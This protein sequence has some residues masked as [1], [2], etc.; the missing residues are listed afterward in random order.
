MSP[1]AS[2]AGTPAPT[3]Q[4]RGGARPAP[5]RTTSRAE[6]ARHP[7]FAELSPEVG[8]LDEDALESAVQ[9]DPDAVLALLADLGRAT[10]VGLRAAAHRLAGRLVLDRASTGAVRSAGS[11]RLRALPADRGGDLDVDA[12]LDALLEARGERRPASLEHLTA[13]HWGRPATALVVVVDR[14]GSMAGERL[15]VAAL[16]A[17]ACALRAPR[18]HAV[19]TFAST[20]DVLRPLGGSA[21]PETVVRAVLGLRG[22]GE[23]GLTAALD[24]AATQ[25]GRTTAARRIVLLLSDCRTDPREQPLPSALRL[26]ELIVLAPA[27]DAEMAQDLA[28]RAGARCAPVAGP[29][30]VPALLDRLLA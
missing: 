10:D 18:D 25:L 26:P 15:A 29:S 14:S 2:P 17:A 24:E 28:R 23:T 21:E 3:P 12:S 5:L 22:H 6:L 9:Q 4:Q 27:D 8:V 11:R 30:E 19:L 16:V 7:R 13:R 1:P 20:V